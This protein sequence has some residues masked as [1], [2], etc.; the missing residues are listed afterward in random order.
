VRLTSP[1]GSCIVLK[2]R[3]FNDLYFI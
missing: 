3:S 1:A 2:C